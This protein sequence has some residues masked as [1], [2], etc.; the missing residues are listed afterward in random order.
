MCLFSF[1]AFSNV[2]VR[3]G[4]KPNFKCDLH[5]FRN[6]FSVVNYMTYI[7]PY[8]NYY[9]AFGFTQLLEN[10]I[11][12]FDYNNTAFIILKLIIVTIVQNKI[13]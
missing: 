8:K 1:Y 6:Y 7:H 13:M 11:S 3:I 5:G 10:H 12:F 9:N 4:F 2:N